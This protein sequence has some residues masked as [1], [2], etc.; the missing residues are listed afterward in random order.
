MGSHHPNRALEHF[1][2]PGNFPHA[3][4]P[5]WFNILKI[6]ASA[7]DCFSHTKSPREP[8]CVTT[9]RIPQ[10]RLAPSPR[11]RKKPSPPSMITLLLP[12]YLHQLIQQ[13]FR[14]AMPFCS[15]RVWIREGRVF[16]M[17]HNHPWSRPSPLPSPC[18]HFLIYK[19]RSHSPENLVVPSDSEEGG[20]G[21]RQ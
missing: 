7:V 14:R 11:Y 2:H 19:T 10:T 17:N 13:L 20:G 21:R 15:Q 3:R 18:S 9:K 16:P 4:I 1:Y 12:V 5:K 6:L 8:Q